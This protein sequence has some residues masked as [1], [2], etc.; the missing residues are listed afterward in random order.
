MISMRRFALYWKLACSNIKANRRMYVPYFLA[1]SGIIMMYF[2]LLNFTMNPGIGGNLSIMLGMGMFIMELFSFVFIFYIKSF[3]MKRRE[4]EFGL[5]NI[6][7]MEKKQ[8]GFLLFIETCILFICTLVAGFLFGFLFS[9]LMQLLIV[10]LTG[11]QGNFDLFYSV[12]P[13]Y[14]TAVNFLMYEGCA[15]LYA[16]WIVHKSKPIELLHADDAGEKEPKTKLITAIVGIVTLGFGYYLAQTIDNPADAII[17]F[18]LAALSVIIGTYCLFTS[19]SIIILKALRKNKKYYYQKNHFIN[20]SGMLYRMKQNAM[21]LANICILSCMV[22]VSISLTLSVYFGTEISVRRL[23]PTDISVRTR[24]QSN[25]ERDVFNAQMLKLV[26]NETNIQTIENLSYYV[27]QDGDMLTDEKEN[28]VRAML[29]IYEMDDAN[30]GEEYKDCNVLINTDSKEDIKQLHIANQ[31]IQVDRTIHDD[32]KMLKTERMV[33]SANVYEVFVKDIFTFLPDISQ[34]TSYEYNFDIADG[35]SEAEITSTIN[36]WFG[37]ELE[38]GMAFFGE[39]SG[40][41]ESVLEVKEVD[42]SILFIGIF[43]AILFLFAT[44]L[45]MYYKQVTEGYDDLERYHILQKVGLSQQEVKHSINA[46]IIT[47]FFL[48]LVIAIIHILVAYHME[49]RML[50]AFAIKDTSILMQFLCIT[51][52]IFALIYF[53]VYRIT[54]RVYYNII[55]R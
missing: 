52:A 32:W 24:I 10:K 54:S 45:I 26:P 2:M 35:Q 43:L 40:I 42:G 47:V 15:F 1:M 4:K 9:K 11:I 36:A 49:T 25:E 6:L 39:A 34:N 13:V 23:N 48:P 44:V 27:Y 37:T 8:V 7:G 14:M 5:Y 53:I 29:M 55:K 21:G 51:I 33:S 22:I 50:L 46:Q 30:L 38:N 19:I 28:D 12:I 20:V 18:L 17:Y 3:L 31:T 16:V 41:E